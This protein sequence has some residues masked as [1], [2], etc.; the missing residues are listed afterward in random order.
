MRRRVQSVIH[1]VGPTTLT[2]KCASV[3]SRAR[4]DWLYTLNWMRKDDDDDDGVFVVVVDEEGDVERDRRVVVGLVDEH[5]RKRVNDDEGRRRRGTTTYGS[6]MEGEDDTRDSDE[7]DDDD[8]DLGLFVSSKEER[9]RT[10]RGAR[11]L[12]TVGVAALAASGCGRALAAVR[13]IGTSTM[14]IRYA[15]DVLR[16]DAARVDQDGALRSISGW[17]AAASELRNFGR[18]GAR[19][20]KRPPR[21]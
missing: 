18:V 6:T 9:R 8:D 14:N 13:E 17:D 12:A 20:T 15:D 19:T 4:T 7:D 16:L 11:A 10:T 3:V 5:Q 2:P 1:S 21:A